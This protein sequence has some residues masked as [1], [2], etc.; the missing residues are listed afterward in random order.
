[1][2][3]DDT[4]TTLT[5]HAPHVPIGRDALLGDLRSSIED[6]RAMTLVGPGGVGKTTLLRALAG[7]LTDDAW[8]VAWTDLT[9]VTDVGAMA[10][11]VAHVLEA[12]ESRDE[13]LEAAIDRSLARRPTLLVLDNAEDVVAPGSWIVERL[14]AT[15][16]L[17]IRAT[18]RRPLGFADEVVEQV[19]G[20]AGP[21]D[22]RPESIRTSPAGQLFLERA[23]AGGRRLDLA[24]TAGADVAAL[25]DRLDGLPLAIELAAR[26]TRIM[27]PRSILERLDA[28]DLLADRSR[29]PARHS[30]LRAALHWSLGTLTPAQ[31]ELLAAISAWIGRFEID[32]VE[33]VAPG[34]GVLD[35][36]DAL[37]DLGLV[38]VLDD[39]G[40]IAFRVLETVRDA[41]DPAVRAAARQRL[42]WALAHRLD[43]WA[44]RLGA[45]RPDEQAA[46]LRGRPTIETLVAELGAREPASA[47]LVVAAAPY[48][49]EAGALRQPLEA[50]RAATAA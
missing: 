21:S 29:V 41:I 11:R 14:T 24:G 45:R 2:P 46:F 23:A 17:V 43:A 3:P 38:Q 10:A 36:L 47:A 32:A 25:L 7:G 42:A 33:L 31:Q 40:A 37:V 16:S 20:L 35:D 9:S 50:C 4:R 30:S 6:V 8:R 48:W 18:S 13:L 49:L 15:S 44:T 28:A 22:A 12:V 5:G 39:E 1:M 19:R 34:P 27:T 26:R